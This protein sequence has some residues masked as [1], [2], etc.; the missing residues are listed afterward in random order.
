MQSKSAPAAAN[1]LTSDLPAGTARSR[2]PAVIGVGDRVEISEYR[3]P[4]FH[5]IVRV[6]A[7]ELISLAWIKPLRIA[8]LTEDSAARVIE[9]ALT[10]EGILLHPHITIEVL[11]SVGQDVSVLGEVGHPGIY[12]YALHH[13][14]LDLLAASSGLS[15]SAGSV[16]KIY[17]RND[18]QHPKVVALQQSTSDTDSQ[19]NPELEPG[20]TIQVSRA[21]LVYV[22]GA[23]IRPG[24]YMIENSQGL[25]VVKAMSL[26]WGPVQN[27]STRQAL[28]IREQKGGRALTSLNL[29]RILH[30]QDP[31]PQIRDG[32]I[33][34]IP[35]SA[36]KSLLHRSIESAIQSAMGVAIYSGLVYSQRY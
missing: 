12:P 20:D 32:D 5:A 9:A 21:G 17:H 8:G 31:D 16:V 18:P 27:A 7:D 22:I 11:E 4:E 6:R 3:T 14:L 10:S 33:L 34:Y 19:E 23:V 30:G 29:K 2:V 15:A 1:R 24:G 36:A 13:R 25:T 28:L 35:D 26:A